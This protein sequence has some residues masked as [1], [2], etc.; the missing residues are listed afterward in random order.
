MPRIGAH[1]SSSG[2]YARAVDREVAVGGTCGQF[3]LERSNG[4]EPDPVREEDVRAFRDGVDETGVRPWVVRAGDAV[5]LA[6][7]DRE[8]GLR[9]LQTM[10]TELRVANLLGVSYYVVAPGEYEGTTREVGTANVAR[11]LSAVE[12]HGETTV[13]LE[14]AVG[15]GTTLG[16]DLGILTSI[17][18]RSTKSLG[19]VGLCLDTCSLYAA[20]YD[21]A[22]RDGFLE[23][24]DAVESTV[25]IEHVRCLHFN[26]SP[27]P[28]GSHREGRASV[29]QGNIGEAG[30]E[31]ML[32]HEWFRATPILVEPP[33]SGSRTRDVAT[34]RG[35][36][37]DAHEPWTGDPEPP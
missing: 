5:D 4:P 21:V 20:G 37:A 12:D 18:E 23:V 1:V 14:N 22:T 36:V 17:L 24:L 33:D 16:A 13:L 30:F 32:N 15:G 8:A 26:D 28:V 19:D 7:P 3:S 34:L 2:G 25:G 27:H 31:R 35:L 10:Q 29:G 9:S 6:T 11:R